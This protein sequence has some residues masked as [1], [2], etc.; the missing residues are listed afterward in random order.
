MDKVQVIIESLIK[1]LRRK[2]GE[3]TCKLSVHYENEHAVISGQ[4]LTEKQRE[5]LEKRLALAGHNVEWRV[6]IIA[7]MADTPLGWAY[8]DK[9]PTNVW[10]RTLLEDHLAWLASQVIVKEEPIRLLWKA[11]DFY[12]VQLVD[13]TI[14]WI[15]ESALTK[16]VGSP[17][18]QPPQQT[19]ANRQEFLS[20]ID[21]CLGVPYLRG[22]LTDKGIDCSGLTQN[23]FRHAFQYL[24][25]RHSMDQML[26]G[27]RVDYPQLADLAFF[28][29][30]HP[31]SQKSTGHVGIVIDADKLT[32]VHANL[33]I[34]KKVAISTLSEMQSAGYSFL[35][36]RRYGVE[37]V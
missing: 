27:Q 1:D 30:H 17:Q 36:Y 3:A 15:R 9:I 20:Y 18:W 24:L 12:C 14:G 7:N 13:T 11:K 19:V 32:I 5:V 31:G 34:H 21:R 35:G 23:V 25:P 26:A 8:V 16:I 2:Y 29:F 28:E 10:S 4:M 6:E 33:E 22:G 37:V